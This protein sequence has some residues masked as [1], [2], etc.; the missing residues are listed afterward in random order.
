MSSYGKMIESLR[1]EGVRLTPQRQMVLEIV[2]EESGHLS[3]EEIHQRVRE[4]Y[5]YVDLSTIYRILEFL[6][7]HNIV[8]E[9]DLGG[10]RLVFEQCLE[11]PH[12]HLVCRTCGETT[13]LT[14]DF[15]EP[16]ERSLLEAYGF[17]ADINHLA[18][19]GVC[20]KCR[21]HHTPETEQYPTPHHRNAEGGNPDASS[22]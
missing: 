4:R 21:A 11:K 20:V 9:T 7:Q 13:E 5:P 8:T 16:L 10:G 12:H 14:H 18:I 6:K 22:H 17:H 3:A 15:L 2:A 19:F 1:D